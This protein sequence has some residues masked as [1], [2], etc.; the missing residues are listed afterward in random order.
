[1]KRLNYRVGSIV[2]CK[3]HDNRIGIVTRISDYDGPHGIFIE[4]HTELE[5]WVDNDLETIGHIDC[6]TKSPE[7]NDLYELHRLSNFIEN[8]IQQLNYHKQR[9]PGPHPQLDL[10]EDK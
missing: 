7:D 6:F 5:K 4:A 10:L 3:N 2:I 8:R 1:M 9:N